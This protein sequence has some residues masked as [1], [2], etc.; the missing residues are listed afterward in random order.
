M[1]G[2]SKSSQTQTQQLA[3]YDPAKEGLQGILSGITSMVPQAGLS[4]KASGALDTIESNAANASSTF[5]PAITSGTLGLLNGGGATANDSAI[6][7]NF[8]DYKGLLSSTASGAN[9]GNNEALKAQLDQIRTDVTDQ[10]N[11]MWAAAGRDFSPGNFQALARGVAA[12]Q[13]PVIA[14]QYNADADR[15]LGAASAIYGAGNTTYGLLNGT[16]AAANENFTNGVG[17]AGKA[18]DASNYGANAALQAEA[19]RFGIPASQYATLLGSLA[20]VAAQFG[21]N[22]GHSEGEQT[23]SGAQQFAMIA[24]GLG[25]LWPKGN[26]SFGAS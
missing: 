17:T 4:G 20:P 16:N 9:V 6:K 1:G 12:G 23:M 25:S 5:S 22:T 7:Q 24:Q 14:A 13:A 11:G 10:T 15:A 18:I 2:T 21:Q 19:Q 8:A 26:I 3:P